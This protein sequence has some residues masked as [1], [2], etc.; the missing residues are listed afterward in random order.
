MESEHVKKALITYDKLPD[1]INEI[2][3]LKMSMD[4]M[5]FYDSSSH[6]IYEEKVNA[7]NEVLDEVIG[8]MKGLLI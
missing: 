2:E 7:V 5:I 4:G 1:I 3:L 6:L 8:I